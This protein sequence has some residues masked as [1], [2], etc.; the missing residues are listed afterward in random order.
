M[1]RLPIRVRLTAAFAT[2]MLL[3]LTTTAGFVYARLRAD[4]DDAIDASLRARAEAALA[5]DS[6]GA[7]LSAAALEDREESL[8]QVLTIDGDVV[9]TA[10]RLSGPALTGAEARKAAASP[11]WVERHLPGID[12]RARLLAL[13]GA[14]DSSVI[15]VGQSLID[16]Q[17]AL[18]SVVHSFLVGGLAAVVLASVIGYLLASAAFS[19]VEAMRRQARSV[20]LADPVA[21]L[22][23]PQARDELRRLGETLNDMLARLQGSFVRERHFVADASHELRTP[24]AVIQTEINT[25]LA[26]PITDPESRAALVAASEECGRLARLA[27]DLLLIERSADGRLP[28]ATERVAVGELLERARS[29]FMDRA[30]RD[31]RFIDVQCEPSTSVEGDRQRLTQVFVNLLDNALRYGEG[32]VRLVASTELG[33]VRVVV[34]DDGE[35]FS[36]AFAPL[37]FDRFSRAD[38]A[39]NRDGSGLGLSIVRTIVEAHGGTVT[40]SS[41]RPAVVSVHLPKRA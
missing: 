12:G 36:P 8:V 39:R 2:A 14:A 31:G 27:D 28:L 21:T 13:A 4:L 16:R 26:G 32:E 34:E 7:D 19:P 38:P 25:V 6:R 18:A 40:A 30:A 17:D 10:G 29:T 37:A 23:L 24:I 5:A 22:P 33:A 35:G 1:K 9:S 20:S 15:V 41:G 11:I 3:M